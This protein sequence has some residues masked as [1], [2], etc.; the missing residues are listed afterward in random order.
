LGSHVVEQA[1][2]PRIKNVALKGRERGKKEKEK[3]RESDSSRERDKKK[4]RRARNTK[5]LM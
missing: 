5:R 2:V 1:E 3:R 4:K